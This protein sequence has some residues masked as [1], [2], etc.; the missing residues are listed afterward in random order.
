MSVNVIEK[1]LVRYSKFKPT[2]KYE[3]R[4]D[5]LHALIVMVSKAADKDPNGFDGLTDETAEWYDTAV[6]AHNRKEEVPDFEVEDVD[7]KK[8]GPDPEEDDD[9]SEQPEEASDDAD[10]N[11]KKGAPEDPADSDDEETAET[12]SVDDDAEATAA[13]EAE[14]ES[15]NEAEEAAE[16]VAKAKPKGKAKS[17]KKAKSDEPKREPR[18]YDTLEKNR[19]GIT[20]G[21][22][23]H[24]AILMYEKGCTYADVSKELG[25]KHYN[26]L[27]QLAQEGHLFE[28]F[29]GGKVRLTHKDDVNK[30]PKKAKK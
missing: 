8:P 24:D 13:V 11:W 20:M 14:V 10:E 19:Y 28:K 18:V 17:K 27:K 26:I 29:E 3:D 6:R 12:G 2:T 21:T 15:A 7:E 22:K 16:Y 4:Q 1:E 25:G 9:E 5:Y 23:T 30:A